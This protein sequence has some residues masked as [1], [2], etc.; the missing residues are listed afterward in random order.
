[1]KANKSRLVLIVLAVAIVI[2]LVLF[3][4]L[5][6]KNDGVTPSSTATQQETTTGNVGD[7]GDKK[8]ETEADTEAD[9]QGGILEDDGDLEISIPDYM[10]TTGE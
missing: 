1:M 5:K 2:C 9:D 3:F 4:S 8:D 7:D 6:N 10:E